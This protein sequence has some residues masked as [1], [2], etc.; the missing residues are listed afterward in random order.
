MVKADTNGTEMEQ[1][2]ARVGW[3]RIYSLGLMRTCHSCGNLNVK[4]TTLGCLKHGFSTLANAVCDD[5][6]RRP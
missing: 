3:V 5:W 4:R 1:L 6:S 2:R